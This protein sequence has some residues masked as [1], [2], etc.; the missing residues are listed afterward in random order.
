MRGMPIDPA[1]RNKIYTN[2]QSKK[3]EENVPAWFQ[4]KYSQ[5][6][7]IC[8]AYFTMEFK[9]SEA[10]LLSLNHAAYDQRKIVSEMRSVPI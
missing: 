10:F 8:L 2:I 7:L 1:F 5:A 3:R 9:L 6:S 4:K